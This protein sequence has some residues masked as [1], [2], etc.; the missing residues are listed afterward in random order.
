MTPENPN[1]GKIRITHDDLSRVTVP[2]ASAAGYGNVVE[3]A[4]LPALPDGKA[5]IFLKEWCY[6]GL[7]GLGGALV[8]WSICEPWFR[9]GG[10]NNWANMILIPLTLVLSCVG[11][12]I[13][14]SI[15][16]RSTRKAVIRG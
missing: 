4:D 2:T 5:S 15:A 1:D 13:A 12:G 8:A 6:L 7:A 3:N 11:F 14:E 16:E 9:D 10:R